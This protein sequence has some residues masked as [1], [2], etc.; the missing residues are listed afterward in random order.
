MHCYHKKK[1][2]N[3]QHRNFSSSDCDEV[4]QYNIECRCRGNQGDQGFP[5]Q[6]GELGPIGDT[7]AQGPQ[8]SQGPQGPQGSQGPLGPSGPQGPQGPQGLIGINGSNGSNGIQGSQGPSG[9]EGPGCILSFNSGG[10]AETGKFIGFGSLQ[11]NA[12]NGGITVP[13]T[14]TVT[15]WIIKL[16]GITTSSSFSLYKNNSSNFDCEIL[17][18]DNANIYITG[19]NCVVGDYISVLVLNSPN[20]I[21]V[22]SSIIYS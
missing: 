4:D 13:F 11:N 15:K 1:Y 16:N 6:Q 18:G 21:A 5:G 12:F 14:G 2:C 8:G 7:G 9:P 22:Q 19:F 20:N 3:K 10:N 17:N